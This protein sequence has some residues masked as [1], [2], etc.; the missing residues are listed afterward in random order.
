MEISLTSA[1][2][3]TRTCPEGK[4]LAHGDEGVM[5]SAFFAG[6]QMYAFKVEDG[7]YVGLWELRYMGY[8]LSSLRDAA[9]AMAHGQAFARNVL[10]KLSGSIGAGHGSISSSDPV[11]DLA[12]L[13]ASCGALPD[14]ISR[15]KVLI[16]I[17]RDQAEVLREGLLSL[18]PEEQLARERRAKD[19]LEDLARRIKGALKQ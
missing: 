8:K 9:E 6:S 5:H 15:M 7:P 12:N 3:L 2:K 17:I 14:E 1:G 4:W 10:K 11:T 16:E 18:N 13:I 19:R